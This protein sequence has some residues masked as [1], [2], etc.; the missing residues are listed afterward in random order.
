LKFFLENWLLILVAFV[1]G[2]MLVW[3]M[4]QAQRGGGSA[5]STARPCA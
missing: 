2:G 3:P 5:V 4:V 1:S